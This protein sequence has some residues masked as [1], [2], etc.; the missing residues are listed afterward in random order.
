VGVTVNH[1]ETEMAAFQSALRP[2]RQ[3]LVD[4]SEVVA[5]SP[6]PTHCVFMAQQVCALAQG[7]AVLPMEQHTASL[8]CCRCLPSP[9]AL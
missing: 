3:L 1:F 9:V 7:V 5:T 4:V 6:D 8:R 2:D